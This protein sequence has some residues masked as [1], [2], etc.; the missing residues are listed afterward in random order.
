[1]YIYQP[2][3]A[4]L[5]AQIK[6]AAHY[7]TGRVLDVGCGPHSRYEHFF[8]DA[9]SY[10]R[11]D[12][13]PGEGVDIVGSA[14]S[15]PCED[16][17]FDSVVSTQVFEHLEFPAESAAEIFRVLK[18]GGYALITVPQWN[19][20]HEEPH[21]YFRYTRFGLESL[22]A[23]A[24]FEVVEMEKRGGY[25]TTLAQVRTRYYLDRYRLHSR[26]VLGWLA[27]YA[28]ALYG[29]QAVWRDERDTSPANAKHA[30]G[31]C[32]VF[33]KGL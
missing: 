8:K 22:F 18:P 28:F 31:W 30:I 29:K 12:I 6:K 1:M 5:A 17:S 19:E 23:R 20:M 21:D 26:P 16:T 4:L 15:I 24:G 2:D 7:I 27:R 33:K 11:M 13:S 10:V 9:A 25:R 3:R 32:A 14:D